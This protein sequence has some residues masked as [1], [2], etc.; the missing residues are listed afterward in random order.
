MCDAGL[1]YYGKTLENSESLLR[2][3]EAG[4]LLRKSMQEL[5]SEL[6]G[7]LRPD[8]RAV[9]GGAN[10]ANLY[11]IDG[12]LPGAEHSQAAGPDTTRVLT[13]N[14]RDVPGF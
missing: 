8:Q 7:R 5:L 1:A 9:G 2:R 12:S 10:P 3:G 4:N 13:G 14:G 11:S 6:A